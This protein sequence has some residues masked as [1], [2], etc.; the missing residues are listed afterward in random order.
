[1]RHPLRLSLVLVLVGAAAVLARPSR[2]RALPALCAALVVAMAGFGFDSIR[3]S[4]ARSRS[5][6]LWSVV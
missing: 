4:T 2:R 6:Y 3:P 5:A 1:M